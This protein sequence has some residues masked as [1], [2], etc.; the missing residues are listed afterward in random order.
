MRRNTLLLTDDQSRF[1]GDQ[2]SLM[3]LLV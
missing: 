3:S 1:L 2:K